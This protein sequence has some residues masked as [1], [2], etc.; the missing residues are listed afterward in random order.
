MI[1]ERLLIS[2]LCHTAPKTPNV[3][4]PS[5]AGAIAAWLRRPRARSRR[6]APPRLPASVPDRMLRDLGITR[7]DLDRTGFG[8]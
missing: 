6:P 4:I 8:L 3:R 1:A 5:P 7:A 2:A